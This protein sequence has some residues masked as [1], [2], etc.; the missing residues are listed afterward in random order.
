[1][2]P[3]Q[4]ELARWLN[5]HHLS[6][7]LNA[8]LMKFGE[9]AGEVFGAAVAQAEGLEGKFDLGQEL[10]Q[11]FMCLLG[12]AYAAGLDLTEEIGKEWDRMQVREWEHLK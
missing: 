4:Y 9:E 5:N 11:T 6:I 3:T 10:A 2:I 8:R 7:G 12:I 1:M